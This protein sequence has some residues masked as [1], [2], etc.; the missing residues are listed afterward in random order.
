MNSTYNMRVGRSREI[1][2]PYL[3]RDGVDLLHGGGTLLL[4]TEGTMIG[5]GH[6]GLYEEADQLLLSYHFYD[7]TRRGRPR[8]AV[9]PLTWTEDGWPAIA[10]PP[11]TPRPAE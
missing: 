10:G 2:G 11:I 6:A 9:R 4:E 1:T 5:P 8:L 3:D 7:G